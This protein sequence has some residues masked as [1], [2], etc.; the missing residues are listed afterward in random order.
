MVDEK[1]PFTSHL[2]ELR[3]RLIICFIAV[4]IGFVASYF[5][6]KRIFTILMQ[7][8][9]DVLPPDGSLIFTGL[10]EAFFTYLKV[11]LLAGIFVASPVVLYQIWSF[12]SPGLYQKEKRYVWPFVIFSTIFFAGGALFGYFIVF[13]FGF[14]FFMGFATEA[15]RPLPSMKEYFSFSTKLLFAFGIVFELPLFVFFLSKIGVVNAKML[16]SQRKYAIVIIFIASAILTPPDVM[17]QLMMAVPL[18]LLYELSIWVAKVF[19][20]SEESS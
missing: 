14:K 6:S 9:L 19:G 12:I 4:G 18:L 11:S 17:T 2:E 15:I 5:F 7:P 3:R 10:A 20:K 16:T 8:L 13:P 1:L